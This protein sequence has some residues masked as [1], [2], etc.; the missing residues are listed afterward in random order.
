MTGGRAY[1]YDE[2]GDF[3]SSVNHESVELRPFRDGDDDNECLALIER[4]W[5]ETK[6][7][8]ARGLLDDWANARS[9]VWVVEPREI[10]ARQKA[11]ATAAKSA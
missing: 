2:T 3:E 5:R 9:K 1:V 10:L 4:H 11:I 7:P 8:R 6:S